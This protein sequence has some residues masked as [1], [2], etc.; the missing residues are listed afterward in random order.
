M[1]IQKRL[2]FRSRKNN[3]VAAKAAKPDPL[4]TPLRDGASPRG[5]TRKRK[6]SPRTDENRA[7]RIP[8]RLEDYFAKDG[9]DK[10]ADVVAPV[11]IQ[12]AATGLD[13]ALEAAQA[14][15]PPPL[16]DGSLQILS[17]AEPARPPVHTAIFRNYTDKPTIA[18]MSAMGGLPLP[19]HGKLLLAV[20]SAVDQCIVFNAARSLASVFHRMIPQLQMATKR[21]ITHQHLRQILTID[22]QWYR[23]APHRL[24]ADGR[25]VDTVILEVDDP[26]DRTDR[27]QQRITDYIKAIH[28]AWCL[29]AQEAC[30]A[31][32]RAWH[33]RFRLED[34]Q[35]PALVDG[36]VWKDQSAAALLADPPPAPNPSQPTAG[37]SLLERIRQKE[38]LRNEQ[39]MKGEARCDERHD[40]TIEAL[41][42]LLASEKKNTMLLGD[43]TQ[44]LAQSARVP[45]SPDTVR[46][47]V[48]Q[49]C[50][51]V[52]E[53]LGLV[54]IQN[55]RFV[56]RNPEFSARQVKALVKQRT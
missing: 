23:Y 30:P 6:L 36:V 9:P 29:A 18:P 28:S 5:A 43:I 35:I 16:D 25:F 11:P 52:P 19:S 47:A 10:A 4:Q 32:L 46:Q 27:F 3:C 13:L 49:L 39:I 44:R 51:L 21:T 26:G 33:P 53:C 12:P 1:E 50:D 34:V 15:S 24:R 2:D 20:M 37:L 40:A 56:K 45:S 38:K 31:V 8:H 48:A 42:Y 7:N 55:A 41:Y 54:T 14:G 17:T 22:R